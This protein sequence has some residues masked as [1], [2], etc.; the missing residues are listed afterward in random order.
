MKTTKWM[1]VLC[2]AVFVFGTISCGGGKYADAKKTIS[3]SNKVLETFLGE[4][5]KADSAEAIV[6][7][8]TGFS[9]E[10]EKFVPEMK[11][12]QEKYPE[13]EGNQNIPESIMSE[14]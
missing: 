14:L 1:I 5:D 2:V 12:L 13:L 7:A 9:S 11:K 3:D 10:M 4:M 6:T 8:L